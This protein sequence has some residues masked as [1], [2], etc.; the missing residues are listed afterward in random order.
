M[1]TLFHAAAPHPAAP[2]P[3]SPYGRRALRDGLLP[4]THL[5]YIVAAYVASAIVLIGMVAA[6]VLDLGRQKR[7]LAKLEAEGKRRRS[8]VSR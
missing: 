5:G 7:R 1:R 8:E 6:V 4:M 2:Q 3:P